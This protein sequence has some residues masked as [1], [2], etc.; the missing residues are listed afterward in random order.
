MDIELVMQ[1]KFQQIVRDERGAEF[2][3]G[4]IRIVIIIAFECI[5][6]GKLKSKGSKAEQF[7]FSLQQRVVMHLRVVCL[8]AIL[9][10]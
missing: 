4:A 10:G 5:L 9:Q 6:F 8:Y 7:V 2:E 3:G 1:G